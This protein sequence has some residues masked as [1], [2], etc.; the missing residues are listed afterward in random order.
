VAQDSRSA[1]PAAPE[2]GQAADAI[3][4][5]PTRPGP[6]VPPEP[7]PVVPSDLP[8]RIGRYRVIKILGH[9]GF[10]VVYLAHDDELDRFVAIKVPHRRLIVRPEDATLYRT[11]ARAVAALDHPHIVPVF[12]VGKTEDFPF[13][14]VSKFIDG[15]TLARK[16]AA[17]RP[18]FAETKDLV[19]TVAD[20]LHHAHRQGLVHRDIKPGNILIDAVGRP[21]VVDFGLVLREEDF[22]KE[23]GGGGTPAYM[24]PEQIRGE[25]HRV[26]E[27]SDVFSLGVVLYELLTGNRPFLAKTRKELADQITTLEPAPPHQIDSSVPAELERICLKALSKRAMERYATAKDMAN[28]LRLSSLEP[29]VGA[30]G[31]AK[32]GGLPV[33]TNGTT[34]PSPNLAVPTQALKILPK[35]LRSFDEHDA[36]F[37][38]ELLPGPR[39]R[40]GL[41]ESIHFWKTAIE[42]SDGNKTFLVGLIYGPSGCGKSS[43]VKAGLL[44]RL[45]PDVSA[46][47]LE[48]S[49]ADLESRL[50]GALR[51]RCPALP[52]DLTLKET[53]AALRH[54][55]HLPAGKKM[56]IVLDQFEQWL[57]ANKE[58]ENSELV[59]ALRQCD[60]GRV[61]CLVMVRDDFWMAATRFMRQLEIPLL[62]GRNS[63][64]VDLFDHDHA[65][66]VLAAFG[67]AFGKLPENPGQ[68]SREQQQFLSQALEELA[69]EGKFVCVRLVVFAE[70]MKARR[71]SPAS[72]KAV[73]GTQGLG[74]TFL[75]ETFRGTTAPPAHRYHEK[76]ARAVLRALLP[77][78]GTDIKLHS[79]SYQ[80]LLEASE[81]ARRPNEQGTR[82]F[83]QLLWILDQ[84]VR[85]ITP[86]TRE[87]DNSENAKEQKRHGANSS[88][89]PYPSSV[90]YY[91][92]THDY[93]VHS[94][95]DWLTRRQQETRRGRAELLLA[96]RAGVWNARPENRQLPSLWQLLQIR[97]L[98]PKKDWTEPQHKMV[99]KATRYHAAWGCV[100]ALVVVGLGIWGFHLSQQRA[101]RIADLLERLIDVPLEEVPR[102]IAQMESYRSSINPRLEEIVR[103]PWSTRQAK[104]R[105]S[106]A[107]LP[108]DSS[109]VE[110]LYGRLLEA[111]PTEAAALRDALIPHQSDLRD[112]LWTALEQPAKGKEGQRLRAAC[113]L[114]RY[115]PDS[116]R[117]PKVAEP[118]VN[119]FVAAS[120]L[121]L[122]GWR[123]SLRPLRKQLQAALEA[124]YRNANRTAV[125]RNQATYILADYAA[126][127][128]RAL[129]DLLMDAGD[130][131]P[132]AALLAKVKEQ[133]ET[134]LAFLQAEIDR[135]LADA[136][137]E[138]AKEAL[139]KRQANA[140]V[141]L[142]LLDR[143]GKVWTLLEQSPDPRVR[144]Y[145]IHRLGPWGVDVSLIT[146]RLGQE[147]EVTA[148]RA[149]ILSLGAFG[150][151]DWPPGEK[152]RLVAELQ[153]LYQTAPDPGLRT[154]AEWLLR[155]WKQEAWLKE[156]D[157]QWARDNA[158]LKQR[159]DAVQAELANAKGRA[160]PQ[161][162][163]DGQGQT[164]VVIPGPSVFL[165]GSPLSEDGRRDNERQHY[166]RIGRTFALGAKTVTQGQYLCVTG[167]G[168]AVPDEALQHPKVQISWK[169]AALYCNRLSERE[170]IDRSQWCYEVTPDEQ[171]RAK[172]N[173]L[174]LTGYRLPTEA[175][176]EFATRAGAMTCRCY[177]VSEELLGK[178]GWYALNSGARLMP[179]GAL[180]PNDLGLFDM[181]GNVWCWCQDV[182]QPY[183]QEAGDKIFDDQE[184]KVPE[185]TPLNHVIRGGCFNDRGHSQFPGK[186]ILRSADRYTGLPTGNNFIGFRLARTLAAEGRN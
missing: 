174:H 95:R 185:N 149:L 87:G 63:S 137:D 4:T 28:D 59:Q 121:A 125:D 8:A 133:G 170:G 98:T 163:V 13:F 3:V 147:P 75:E 54:G 177:G 172:K 180:K 82:D 119:D 135:K 81:Y 168:Q 88:L 89:I 181:H 94:L 32:A 7:L 153:R 17:R 26:D 176:M 108:V 53:L 92:L 11:E 179:V 143:P 107:L 93:L 154:A 115:D 175:E 141:A 49:A 67:R 129:A 86:S 139:A 20:A 38:L 128:P 69:Q 104:L 72:L 47:Y 39:D 78:P 77:E 184:Q 118:V 70:M 68:T 156:V 23:P 169:Q 126:D 106:W 24:A 2:T 150:N 27:R 102:V 14:C 43:L 90:Q 132:F 127:Q 146:R 65:R 91:Q 159:L 62:E 178:Y 55:Q 183:P 138:P 51:K 74:V 10:G 35:G 6:T 164:M 166:K 157:E 131:Q 84:D 83:D 155:H 73:G 158:R 56:L 50:L 114:G 64:A 162:Y 46:V 101:Q 30:N 161:W 130:Q 96:D 76:A 21:F 22:D 145:L 41:P 186:G 60:G 134:G 1:D 99:R 109:Q 144:S 57:H 42:E 123:H 66:K 120:P 58:K 112:K 148:R 152:E 52:G 97:L 45:S 31:G 136:R 100:F 160:Q 182:Y 151:N 5:E 165:M 37:F 110:Y 15:C 171:V 18:S 16:I 103:A 12:D 85:L 36:D 40:Q 116:D 167:E 142:V 71:W 111:G 113:A 140:A 124:V 79:K 29:A 61:Q 44:P 117:W 173:Y 25:G 9:G 33:G 105:A 122:E 34:T 19:A 48:A 80:E